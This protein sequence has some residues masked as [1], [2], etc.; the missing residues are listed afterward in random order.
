MRKALGILIVL[1]TV[2]G[3]T[4]A[5]TSFVH[6]PYAGAP[7]ETTVAISWLGSEQVPAHI[8]YGIQADYA[9]TGTFSNSRAAP[10]EEDADLDDPLH[11]TLTSLEPDSAYVYRV[12][13]GD[14]DTDEVASPVGH[15]QTAPLPGETVQFAILAD[16]Q[17]QWE[18]ENRLAAVG[19]AIASDPMPFDFILHAGDLVETPSSPIWDHWFDSF[20][21]MLL[22]A[23]FLPVLGN[24]ERGHRSYYDN[25]VL[26]PGDGKYDERWWALHWGDVVIVGLDTN[27]TKASDYI[28]QQDW[29]RLHLSGRELHKVVMFHHPVYSSDAF[30]GSGYSYDVIYH[31]IFVETGV[32]MVINGHA[33]NYERIEVD[34]ITYLV[35]GGGG[36]VPR[37]LA[38]THVPGSVLALEGYNF[39]LRVTA[40]PEEIGVEVVSVAQATEETFELTDGHL[41]DAFVIPTHP[42]EVPEALRL[43]LTL[44]LIGL[45]GVAAALLLWRGMSR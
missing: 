34:G 1:L 39:Y 5:A 14:A 35:V 26:P 19:N 27:V 30:H 12:I 17:W 11:V 28:A 29:A 44:I 43:N 40:T 10:I 21:T 24:H 41:L 37:D 18:G 25:F 22:R 31:P 9:A 32:D 4:A 20:A 3:A 2:A 16:T 6:G 38:E 36:A 15:F 7:A 33:H 23:P 8:E 42:E 13:L 45:L